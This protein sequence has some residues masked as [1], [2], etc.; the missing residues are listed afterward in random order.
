MNSLVV[1]D[2]QLAVNAV[3][4]IVI[5]LDPEGTC[6]GVRTADAALEYVR[7]HAVDVAFLD[8][9]MPQMTGLELAKRIKDVRPNVNIISVTAYEESLSRR[10]SFMQ[11]GTCL[12]P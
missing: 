9:E 1:D 3:V 5:T 8:V 7:T 11:A 6:E 2:K 12:S 10:T 4:R